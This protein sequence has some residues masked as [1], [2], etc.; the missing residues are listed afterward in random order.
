M[1]SFIVSDALRAPVAVV[2]IVAL[3]LILQVA[4]LG[5]SGRPLQAV[6]RVAVDIMPPA[7]LT[8][9]TGH[10]LQGTIDAFMAN[11]AVSTGFKVSGL[12]GA[13]YLRLIQK[14]VKVFRKCQD[15]TG[16]II[17]P[18]HQIEWQYSTPCYALS[19]GLLAAT[20][21]DTDPEL[22]KSG[23]KA[24]NLSVNEMHEYRC[25][26]NHGEFFIQP[27]MMALDLYAKLVPATR[28]AEWKRKLSELDPYKLYPDN[29]RKKSVVY[30][31][32][33]CALAG[34]YLL[35]KDGLN[36]DQEF[37]DEHLANQKIY[38]SDLGMYMD[39]NPH[40]PI[41]YD[42]F[43]RQYIDSILVEGYSGPERG[44]YADRMWRG[45]WASLFMQ[46][47][48]GEVPTGGR[49]AQHIWNEA[50]A[51]V[52][53]EIYAAQYARKGR[54][55]EAGAFKR[56]A[57]LSLKSIERWY[58]PDGSGYVV[59]NRYPIE[60]QY[61]YERYSAQSQYNLLACW[62]MAVA[63]LYAD[64][65]IAEKPAPADIGGYV[66][67]MVADFH[68]VFANAGGTYIE[69][70]TKGDLYYNPTGLI[71]IHIKGS[72]PQLGPSDG[73]VHKWEGRPKVDMGGEMMTV[74]PAWTDASGN[75][76][77]LA[78]YSLERPATV[79]VLEQ[80]TAKVR[81]RVTHEGPFDG[82][83]KVTETITVEPSG[84]TV[85]DS[86]E[87]VTGIRVYYPMLV[88]DG[89]EDTKVDVQARSA[90][91]HLWD[92]GVRFDLLEPSDAK[93]KRTGVRLEGRNGLME[94]LYADV[95]GS[96]ASYRISA[97]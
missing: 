33:V 5:G 59:K 57:H 36:G 9:N 60:A 18:V 1:V 93:L 81:F 13:D 14:Q 75:E 17:D 4:A 69:Y 89:L 31:H 66:L 61:G 84:V 95:K 82:A 27:V 46:S 21:Y 58:R 47:P 35:I 3:L 56:A 72:N 40:N 63:Y 48:F 10:P 51:A 45:A 30:N 28:L 91:L 15:S 37:F 38:I 97:E 6:G 44:F 23:V 79:E 2:F 54:M 92:G 83:S 76:H 39:Q 34:E 41:V 85:E 53:Y 77:R 96:R 26:H 22:L 19:V 43:T 50:T 65:S 74:G 52:T 64:D 94:G 32:N 80:N 20:G 8:A 7:A 71:R 16:A 24:M 12:N 87:G 90:T 78:E 70:E 67:P 62:L 86:V 88:F 11:Q 55:A 73:V 42:E 29:L 68:K 25:A 49:S